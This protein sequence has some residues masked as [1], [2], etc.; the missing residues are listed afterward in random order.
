MESRT[1]HHHDHQAAFMAVLMIFIFALSACQSSAPTPS[2][3][4]IEVVSSTSIVT[5]TPTTGVV[6]ETIT[7]VPTVQTPVVDGYD[8]A[9]PGSWKKLPVIP[10]T[11]SQ[12]VLRLYEMGK[13]TGLDQNVFSKVGDCETS[14]PY[15]LAPFDMRETGYRLGNYS[16]LNGVITAYQGSFEWVSLAAKSGFSIASVL[17]PT[18]ADPKQCRSGESPLVCEIRIHKPAIMFVMFGTNDV[19]TSTPAG[20]EG[21]LKYLLDIAIANN[22]VPVLVTKADNTEGDESMN[23]IITRVAYEYELPVL[24]LWRAMQDLPNGGLQEDGIHLTYAQPFFD[25]P[26]NMQMGWPVRNLVTLQMLDYLHTELK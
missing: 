3:T 17:S 15:F 11:L 1:S 21:N 18:W 13:S 19:K 5:I 9:I 14:S 23:A 2:Q 7:E 4:P 20:F 26:E 25:L 24:N 6:V 12:R 16:S 8:P 22:V 10:E